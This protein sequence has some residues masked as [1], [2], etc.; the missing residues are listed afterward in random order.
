M[1]QSV[2]ETKVAAGLLSVAENGPVSTGTQ[3]QAV[4][5]PEP[6]TWSASAGLVDQ[7]CDAPVPRV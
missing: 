1:A 4:A 2:Q 6:W 7:A 5:L 3:S